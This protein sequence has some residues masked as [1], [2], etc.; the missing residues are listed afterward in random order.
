VNGLSSG[1]VKAANAVPAG[2]VAATHMPPSQQGVSEAIYQQITEQASRLRK[3]YEN[4]PYVSV[5]GFDINIG[6][7]PSVSISFQFK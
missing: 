3:R 2:W 5:D 1:W 6:V 4:N 7:P